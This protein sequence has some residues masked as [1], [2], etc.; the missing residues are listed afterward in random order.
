MQH[1]KKSSKNVHSTLINVIVL[2]KL[3]LF[4]FFHAIAKVDFDSIRVVAFGVRFLLP[5]SKNVFQ[6]FQCNESNLNS[7]IRKCAP[8]WK[9][10]KSVS[11]VCLWLKKLTKLHTR[12]SLQASNWTSGGIHPWRTRNRICSGVAPV[13]ALHIA[14]AASFFTSK[15]S[16]LLP[17]FWI[18]GCMRLFLMTASIWA[19]FPAVILEIVQQV[20]FFMPWR[21]WTTKLLSWRTHYL[22]LMV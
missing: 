15:Y 22:A 21:K 18:S 10:V 5:Q 20:S 7:E 2:V 4:N 6:R 14:Q 13:V 19:W 3:K 17:T 12:A 9:T 8:Q 16:V 11:R 1:L